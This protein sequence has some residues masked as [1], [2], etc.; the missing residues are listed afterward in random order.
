MIAVAIPPAVIVLLPLLYIRYRT[1]HYAF[2]EDGI[3]MR[4]GLLFRREVIVNYARIQDI[5]LKS[6]IVERWLGL[7]RIHLQTASGNAEAELTIEGLREF[8]LVRDFLYRRMHGRKTHAGESARARA[9]AGNRGLASSPAVTALLH[10]TIAE[11]RATRAS[12]ATQDVPR[13]GGP[14][15]V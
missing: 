8:T 9:S 12:L 1:I 7:S 4:W 15:H 14:R 5:N 3:S 6:N 10:E 2:T 13:S 11:L